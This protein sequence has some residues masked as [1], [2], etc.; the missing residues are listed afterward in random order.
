MRDCRFF[1]AGTPPNQRVKKI[2]L[3]FNDL[4]SIDF[5]A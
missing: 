1:Y 4:E 3:F 5:L 2:S